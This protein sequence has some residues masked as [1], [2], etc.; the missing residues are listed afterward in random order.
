MKRPFGVW[1]ITLLFGAWL[2]QFVFITGSTLIRHPR[3]LTQIPGLDGLLNAATM[4]TLSIAV[5]LLFRLR[6]SCAWAFLAATAVAL[7]P[8]LLKL[9]DGKSVALPLG[10]NVLALLIVCVMWVAVLG[11]VWRLKAK[12]VLR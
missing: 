2:A 3:A 8:T 12:G 7:L 4:F 9:V 1:A 5:V 10:S 6:A 11:Y